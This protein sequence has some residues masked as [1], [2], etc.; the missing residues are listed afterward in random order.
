[1]AGHSDSPLYPT[2][3]KILSYIHNYKVAYIS[4]IPLEKIPLIKVDER[5]KDSSYVVKFL[6]QFKLP[7]GEG[8]KHHPY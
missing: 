4:V 2:W 7:P 6:S 1:M 8:C 5:F 3:D